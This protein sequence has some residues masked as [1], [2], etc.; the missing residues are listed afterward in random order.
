MSVK[1]CSKN[2][3]TWICPLFSVLFPGECLSSLEILGA[4]CTLT[5]FLLSEQCSRLHWCWKHLHRLISCDCLIHLLFLA[6]RHTFW[7]SSRLLQII[8]PWGTCWKKQ[9]K[10]KKTSWLRLRNSLLEMLNV[11][12]SM[13]EFFCYSNRSV[14]NL[15]CGFLYRIIV[16]C[17]V[18]FWWGCTSGYLF[19]G[20]IWNGCDVLCQQGLSLEF[21]QQD[22]CV[23]QHV[24]T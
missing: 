22:V 8:S 11:V 19:R 24:G 4:L 20:F 10:T 9:N 16:F 1:L 2:C 6:C 14:E 15:V 13:Y 21:L 5:V 12:R 7:R 17:C 3:P 18:T 23:L